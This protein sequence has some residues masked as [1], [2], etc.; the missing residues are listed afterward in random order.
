MAPHTIPQIYGL[1]QP[2]ASQPLLPRLYHQGLAS[3]MDDTAEQPPDELIYGNFFTSRQSRDLERPYLESVVS[4]L[5]ALA[6]SPL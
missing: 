1:F 6:P 2:S 3:R 5:T 4:D